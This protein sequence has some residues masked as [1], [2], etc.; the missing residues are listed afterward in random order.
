MS[1]ITG[2][3][4]AERKEL[5]WR[6]DRA[7]PLVLLEI[8]PEDEYR[9]GH[10]PRAQFVDRQPL[11]CGD[12]GCEWHFDRH[13][14]GHTFVEIHQVIGRQLGQLL[15]APCLEP[16]WPV[17]FPVRALMVIVGT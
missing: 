8:E 13:C 12:I 16:E 1:V 5:K 11:A 17:L 6:M 14:L 7:E 3:E 10:I 4:R 15:G 9:R 2:V